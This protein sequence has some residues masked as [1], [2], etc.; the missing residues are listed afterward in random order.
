MIFPCR[1]CRALTGYMFMFPLRVFYCSRC[2]AGG[3]IDEPT[4]KAGSP[5]M[6]PDRCY[7]M[8]DACP[9]TGSRL[10]NAL[11]HTSKTTRS[12]CGAL[13]TVMD[14]RRSWLPGSVRGLMP[15]R[16]LSWNDLGHTPPAR[17]MLVTGQGQFFAHYLSL[18]D[19]T[20]G[21]YSGRAESRSTL[22]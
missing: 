13:G 14:Y 7:P 8:Q 1:E 5:C 10:K 11:P 12:S 2:G 19:A 16:L 9:R 3:E 6:S 22:K 4:Q 15:C 21:W 17:E 18:F 20:T